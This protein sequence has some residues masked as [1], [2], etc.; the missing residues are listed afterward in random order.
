MAFTPQ[1]PLA[2]LAGW[3][4]LERTESAQKA[5]FEKGPALQRELDYFRENIGKA[6]T[7]EALVAD[8]RLL[9][10]ALGAFGLGGEIDKKAFVR[11]VLEGG[12]ENPEALASRLTAPGFKK[13]AGAFGFG[14]ATGA[15]TAAAGFA[16]RIVEAY[17]TRAFEAAV[18]ET[19]NDLRLAMNF[20]REIADLS[21][22]ADGGSW[23]SVIGSSPLR[24]VFEK[25]YGL[26]SSFGK[27]DVDRQ[28]EILRDKTSAL[29]GT[30]N[31]SA[32]AEAENVEKVITRFLARA[33]IEAGPSLTAP[34]AAALTLLQNARGSSGLVNLLSSLR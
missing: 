10:V 9:K 11:K 18:G 14:N 27:L 19:N 26:P 28:R 32:F 29:F 17:K 13:L 21:A 34:G 25:A 12:T 3:R 7:A 8:R 24:E 6:T 23:Y 1:I 30:S 2:G 4:F 16:D 15:Q 31:L 20:R 22:G 5:A 33:Q